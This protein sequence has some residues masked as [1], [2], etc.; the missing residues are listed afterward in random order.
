MLNNKKELTVIVLAINETSS[1]EKVIADVSL[2]SFV[3]KIL[4]VSP[5]FVTKDCLKTQKNL[6]K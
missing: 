4:I 3:A 2:F 6:R 5:E 1:L